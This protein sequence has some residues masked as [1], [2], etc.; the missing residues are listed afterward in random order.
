LI[1]SWTIDMQKFGD[2]I[3]NHMRELGMM[4]LLYRYGGIRVPPS[5]IC[6]RNLEE[7]VNRP[8]VC[9]MVN[10]NVTSVHREFYPNIHFMGCPKES[11]VIEQF[12]DFMQRTISRDF[13]GE[14]CFLG[15][16]NRWA[17]ARVNNGQL[18]LIDGKMIGVKTMNDEP[19]LLENLLA[20]DYIE[21]YKNTYGIYLPEK[22]ILN[23]TSFE[24]F[25]R[26]SQKQVLES[27]IIVSKYLLLSLAPDAKK[28]VIEPLRERPGW[29][30]F[31]KVPS[32]A[33]VWGL[34]PNDLGNNLA[35]LRHPIQ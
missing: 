18:G 13:T 30:S 16:F 17:D 29:V 27:R 11:P 19:V 32:G 6:M 2:P 14:L 33:P 34:K 35:Q 1:P 7:L 22:E 8:F 21:I 12:I 26:L 28:G 3:K 23:R 9:E 31:W 10:R 25:A 15:E 24:W 20:N 5:F 4:K